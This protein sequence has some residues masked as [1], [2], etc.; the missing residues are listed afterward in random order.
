MPGALERRQG[1]PLGHEAFQ[2]PSQIVGRTA[3]ARHD[4][5][6]ILAHGQRRGEIF[7]DGDLPS[8]F[9]IDRAIGDAEAA[10]AQHG[11]D[12]ITADGL[13]GSKGYQIDVW[14]G[15][16]I[17]ANA[18]RHERTPPQR[19]HAPAGPNKTVQLTAG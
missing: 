10:L 19:T 12:A 8:E 1:A 9:G 4:G 18:F 2:P 3:R 7:L 17:V 15:V 14:P 11:D 16:V 5:D 6:A 13:A